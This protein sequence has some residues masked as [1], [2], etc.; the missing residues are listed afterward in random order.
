MSNIK[1]ITDFSGYAAADLDS[2]TRTI[3]AGMFSPGTP[4]VNPPVTFPVLRAALV[5]FN[6][7][8]VKLT[9]HA[10]ADIIAF[11]IAR[12]ELEAMLANLGAH[13]NIVAQHDPVMLVGSGFPCLSE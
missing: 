2:I 1:I 11:N 7:A 10:T 13:V 6:D 4:F 3:E 12:H 8:L 5:A 9:G